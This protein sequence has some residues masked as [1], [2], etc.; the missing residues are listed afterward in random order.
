MNRNTVSHRGLADAPA[1]PYLR[2][3]E[4]D[5]AAAGSPAE[6]GG[7]AKAG[8]PA[9][10]LGWPN[11]GSTAGRGAT[12]PPIAAG[13]WMAPLVV[14]LFA[15]AGVSDS[16]NC[17]PVCE[18]QLRYCFDPKQLAWY[19]VPPLRS[20]H[21]KTLPLPKHVVWANPSADGSSAATATA[22]A[23]NETFVKPN[24]L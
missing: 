13:G 5:I 19:G 18:L 20:R 12:A 7:R 21:V 11:A 4:E 22:T 14:E 15:L 9:V 2:G 3:A 1:G 24:N 10:V 8:S 17:G 23:I 6:P 16:V